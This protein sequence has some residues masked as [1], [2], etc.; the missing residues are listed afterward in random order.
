MVD[1]L[2]SESDRM[3]IKKK[4]EKELVNP[5]LIGLVTSEKCEYCDIMRILL[6]ELKSLSRNLLEVKV[7]K[8]NVLLK[9]MLRIDKGPVILIGR[10]GEVRY[11]GAPLGEEAWAFI[12]T[13]TLA[14]NRKHALD[15]YVNYLQDIER[16]V[17]IETV[18]T[19]SCPYCPY[20]VLMANRIALASNGKVISDVIEAYEFPEIANRWNI[21]AVPAIAISV[22]EPYSGEIVFRGIPKIE[23]LIRA[24]IRYGST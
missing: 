9:K 15:K 1:Y 12:E 19:P 22:E 16:I 3:A 5:V 2:L 21:T 20:A 23:S 18:I 14:S 13:I 6:N 8:I 7:S 11:T 10:K 4:F 17:R 24:V